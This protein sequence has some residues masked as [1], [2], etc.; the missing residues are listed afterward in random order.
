MAEETV[1]RGRPQALR[2]LAQ[3]IMK[4]RRG[5]HTDQLTTLNFARNSQLSTMHASILLGDFQVEGRREMKNV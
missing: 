2:N 4:D 1:D 5:V 3:D